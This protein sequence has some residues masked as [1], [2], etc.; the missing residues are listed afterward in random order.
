MATR[1]CD[2]FMQCKAV[3]C[4][5]HSRWGSLS[6]EALA[7]YNYVTQFTGIMV[8]CTRKCRK[9]PEAPMFTLIKINMC[10]FSQGILH[11][12]GVLL[13]RGTLSSGR[14][15]GLRLHRQVGRSMLPTLGACA[16]QS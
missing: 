12:P 5:R 9:G 6:C 8:L 4:H 15:R 3:H 2:P 11:S 10:V 13:T 7:P 1:L 14:C 16:R